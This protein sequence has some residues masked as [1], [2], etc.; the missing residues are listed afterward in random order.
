MLDFLDSFDEKHA[1]TIL[2][3]DHDTVK[4]L[5]D[6]FE[7]TK[8]FQERRSIIAKAIEELKIH[9]EIEEKLFYPAVRPYLE[10]GIM[11]EADEEHHVAK[12]LIAELEQMKGTEEHYDAKFIVLSENIR[13]HI[14]EEE[15]D[16]LS[17]AHK[18]DIDFDAL[19]LQLLARKQELQTMGVPVSL[20]EKLIIQN[21]G[22]ADSPAMAAKAKSAA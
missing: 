7:A 17:K 3:K 8:D 18:L 9:A 21:K 22:P 6:R 12:L 11:T 16:M 13:H 20:E 5:F 10:A 14:K 19:G 1:I 2:K 4:D 15:S